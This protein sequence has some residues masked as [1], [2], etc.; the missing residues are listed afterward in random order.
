[1]VEN[2]AEYKNKIKTEIS[3]IHWTNLKYK[4]SPNTLKVKS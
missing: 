3:M 4:S 2:A 1:M